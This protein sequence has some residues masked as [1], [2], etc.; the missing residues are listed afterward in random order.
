MNTKMSI[1]SKRMD[2]HCFRDLTQRPRLDLDKKMDNNKRL[3][4]HKKGQ[5]KKA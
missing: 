1:A 5:T 3:R 4:Q 2:N